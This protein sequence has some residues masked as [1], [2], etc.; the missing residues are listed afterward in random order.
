MNSI[1]D[2]RELALFANFYREVR[3]AYLRGTPLGQ[4]SVPAQIPPSSL[5]LEARPLRGLP[6][7]NRGAS[8]VLSAPTE[9]NPFQFTTILEANSSS[10]DAEALTL[11]ISCVPDNV[12]YNFQPSLLFGS[13]G[14]AGGGNQFFPLNTTILVGHIIYGTGQATH[15]AFFDLLRGMTIPLN[16]SFVRFDAAIALQSMPVG[17]SPLN[18][19]VQA[20]LG[21]QSLGT[22][23]IASPL[24]LTQVFGLGASGGG[25]DV[26]F[27]AIPPFAN[28]FGVQTDASA[29]APNIEIQVRGT[30]A[31]GLPTRFHYTSDTN[32]GN[33]FENTFPIWNGAQEIVVD[34]NDIANAINGKIIYNLCL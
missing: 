3:E 28:S 18:W 4:R 22:P 7:S 16:A 25:F 34:N 24:R 30:G 21:Y 23:G 9:T 32:L 12:A 29:A 6:A 31:V 19:R 26:G 11:T 8:R 5:P 14:V 13:G 2:P 15:E 20:T 17:V 33:Q 10:L 1:V 27:L